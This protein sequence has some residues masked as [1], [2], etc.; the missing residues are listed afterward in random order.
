MYTVKAKDKNK[1]LIVRGYLFIS[2]DRAFV[3][4]H[5]M[6]GALTNDTLHAPAVEIHKDTICRSIGVQAFWNEQNT[7]TKNMTM[8]FENDIVEIDYCGK[9]Y[10]GVIK[11]DVG[12]YLIYADGL[13]DGFVTLYDVQERDLP[14]VNAKVIGNEV[15]G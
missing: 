3:I 2:A 13:P 4:P 8:L 11:Y 15:L 12:N 5:N 7:N 6:R 10:H 1:E 9:I 14:L